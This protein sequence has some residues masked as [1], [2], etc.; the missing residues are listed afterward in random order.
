M[1]TNIPTHDLCTIV[2]RI[3]TIAPWCGETLPLHHGAAK[4]HHCNM[5]QAS[6]PDYQQ[7]RAKKE[8]EVGWCRGCTNVFV[9]MFQMLITTIGVSEGLGITIGVSEGLGITI[10]V[11][12]GL[13][14]TIGVN[15]GLG[16]T[17]GVSEGVG[18][19][20]GISEGLGITIGVSE[21]LGM[22]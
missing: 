14:I 20:I 18:I 15:E 7:V 22:A 9:N 12:E 3:T 6:Y 17:I 21:G 8:A 10:R 2:Q 5:V 13:G 16:I 19:T 11:S 1:Y 4:H